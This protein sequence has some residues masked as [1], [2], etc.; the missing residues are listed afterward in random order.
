MSKRTILSLMSLTVCIG[1]IASSC[2]SPPTE[3]RSAAEQAIEDIGDAE[4]YAK[5]EY[6]VAVDEFNKAESHMA[7]EEFGEA[8][9]GYEKTRTRGN[10]G[11]RP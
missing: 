2:A 8:R 9:A 4:K 6:Q 10:R 7:A 5:D 3:A 1:L 11:D